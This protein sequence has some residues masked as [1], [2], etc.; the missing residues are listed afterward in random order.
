MIDLSTKDPDNSDLQQTLKSS[1]TPF[2][3]AAC[4]KAFVENAQPFP[5]NPLITYNREVAHAR[6]VGELPP[7]ESLLVW[8]TPSPRARPLRREWIQAGLLSREDLDE[9]DVESDMS[10]SALLE[11]PAPAKPSMSFL[12]PESAAAI[13]EH[14]REAIRLAKAQE[15]LVIEKC[16]RSDQEVPG[17]LFDELI[18]KGSFGRVYKG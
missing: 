6:L 3:A 14:R 5:P 2:T 16:K 10:S 17:Y 8:E 4:A 12:H 13:T 7:K 18:G 9:I 15:K 11:D 1:V